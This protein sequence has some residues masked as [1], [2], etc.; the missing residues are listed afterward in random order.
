M[1]G[2]TLDRIIESYCVAVYISLCSR[3]VPSPIT[4]SLATDRDVYVMILHGIL[5]KH[6][7]LIA[8]KMFATEV[9]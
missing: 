5:Y 1:T 8:E 9:L 6:S 2:E 3:L 4:G 7:N